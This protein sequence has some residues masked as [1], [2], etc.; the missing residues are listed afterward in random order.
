MNKLN[1]VLNLSLRLKL[2]KVPNV[3]K[4]DATKAS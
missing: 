4:Y 3:Q 2:S 1:L